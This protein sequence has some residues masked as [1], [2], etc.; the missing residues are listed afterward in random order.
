MQIFPHRY[1][2]MWG[3][4]NEV[5]QPGLYQ[6][7]LLDTIN[8]FVGDFELCNSAD[9]MLCSSPSGTFVLTS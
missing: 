5:F 2:D 3:R 1:I 7:S 8:P 4:F 6:P 9:L